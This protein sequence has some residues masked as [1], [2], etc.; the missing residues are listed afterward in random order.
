MANGQP[1]AARNASEEA[2][3]ARGRPVADGDR[4][5]R[6]EK[7]CRELKVLAQERL[8]DELADADGASLVIELGIDE[9]K[10]A[11]VRVTTVVGGVG[12]KTR[13]EWKRQLDR[14]TGD[15]AATGRTL[16]SDSH[17]LGTR[18][19]WTTK[20][21]F[22]SLELMLRKRTSWTAFLRLWIRERVSAPAFRS[23]REVPGRRTTPAAPS[24]AGREWLGPKG[25]APRAGQHSS[26][27]G[28]WR[29][30]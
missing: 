20:A 13:A 8:R 22:A 3:L 21:S 30:R 23:E 14:S 17:S 25:R 26:P 4:L 9:V 12:L 18:S 16:A 6:G 11:G 1:G 24:G 15:A 19:V 29:R 27:S 2:H 28:C 10:V 7:L 5:E